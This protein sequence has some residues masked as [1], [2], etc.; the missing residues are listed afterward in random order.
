[1]KVSKDEYYSLTKEEKANLIEEY[2]EYKDM[3]ATGQHI[4]TKSKINDVT[5]TLKA[6]KNEVQ[7]PLGHVAG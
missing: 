1:M 6:V 5:H 3:K 4:S 2:M 7:F